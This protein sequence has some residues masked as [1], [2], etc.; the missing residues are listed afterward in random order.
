MTSLDLRSSGPSGSVLDY[1]DPHVGS[2]RVVQLDAN[3]VQT[4]GLDRFGDLHGALIDRRSTGLLDC[5]SDIASGHRA[6][7]LAGVTGPSGQVDGHILQLTTHF[8]GVIQPANL[9]G[10]TAALDAINLLLCT[11][12][13]AN[14]EPAGNKEVAAVTVLDLNDVTRATELVDRGSEYELHPSPSQRAVEAYGSSATSRAFL[15]AMATRR[16]S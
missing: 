11:T 3:G 13:L 16:C 8:L 15:M 1:H 10:G 4:D 5:G 2:H 7:Q 6:K 14:R 9:P 12:C